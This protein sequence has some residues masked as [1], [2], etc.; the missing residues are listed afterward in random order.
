MA[1]ARP[2]GG[3]LHGGV[4]HAQWPMASVYWPMAIT[5]TM[6]IVAIAMVPELG[7]TCCS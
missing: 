1:M 6:T 4:F 7:A 3:L 2:S 5:V